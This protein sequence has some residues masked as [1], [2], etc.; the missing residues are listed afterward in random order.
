MLQLIKVV[1]FKYFLRAGKNFKCICE[2]I[3]NRPVSGSLN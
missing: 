2:E 1:K 3:R